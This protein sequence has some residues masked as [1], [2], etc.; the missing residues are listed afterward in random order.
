M[1]RRMHD[2]RVSHLGTFA[3][4][5]PRGIIVRRTHSASL[6]FA[7][8][9]TSSILYYRTDAFARGAMVVLPALNSGWLDGRARP[10]ALLVGFAIVAMLALFVASAAL[11]KDQRHRRRNAID[12]EELFTTTPLPV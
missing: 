3:V 6:V 9:P 8:A 7:Q 12:D 1:A 4:P 10:I 11:R 2:G 5:V